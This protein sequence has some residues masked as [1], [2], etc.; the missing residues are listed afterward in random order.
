MVEY[1]N[2]AFLKHNSQEIL[3]PASALHHLQHPS[4][5]HSFLL[6][7]LQFHPGLEDLGRFDIVELLLFI[8]RQ[9]VRHDGPGG[10]Y[11]KVVEKSLEDLGFVGDLTIILVKV[12]FLEVE[13]REDGHVSVSVEDKELLVRVEQTDV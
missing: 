3:V 11:V 5:L 10:V 8:F 9:T 6:L 7:I 12:N 2:L 4:L 13:C 1:Q